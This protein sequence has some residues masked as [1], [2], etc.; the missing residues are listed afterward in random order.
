MGDEAVDAPLSLVG[1]L[2]QLAAERPDDVLLTHVDASGGPV[3]D[4]RRAQ[5]RPAQGIGASSIRLSQRRPLALTKCPFEDR[6][7]S[8]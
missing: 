1:R 7:G 2:R 3:A 6:T 8:R 4:R 5:I